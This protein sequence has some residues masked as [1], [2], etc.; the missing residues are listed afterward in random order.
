MK[1]RNV[2][3]ISFISLA[4]GYGCGKKDNDENP[5]PVQRPEISLNAPADL[6]GSWMLC[7]VTGES[8]SSSAMYTF[9]AD[10]SLE[11]KTESFDSGDCTGSSLVS[12]ILKGSYLAGSGNALDITFPFGQPEDKQFNTQYR[13][14]SVQ[15]ETLLIS[16]NAGPGTDA[17]HRD[18]DLNSNALKLT[19]IAP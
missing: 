7:N 17:E 11:Y 13:I 9:S 6:L 18:Y 19:R 4:F 15:G 3:L 1:T 8:K 16:N 5:S 12:V 10:G 2:L 14:F